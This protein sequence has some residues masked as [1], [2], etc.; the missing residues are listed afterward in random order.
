MTAKIQ[1]VRRFTFTTIRLP[2][3]LHAE[4]RKSLR[5]V[6]DIANDHALMAMLDLSTKPIGRA[7]YRSL[8]YSHMGSFQSD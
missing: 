5:D 1:S 2:S 7:E 6:Y 4:V 8:E 3:H